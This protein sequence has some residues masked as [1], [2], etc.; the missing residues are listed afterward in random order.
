MLSTT[1]RKPHYQSFLVLT[2]DQL[3]LSLRFYAALVRSDLRLGRSLVS[4]VP[5]PQQYD[6]R[7]RSLG[8][9][10]FSSSILGKG[11]PSSSRFEDSLQMRMLSLTVCEYPG[12]EEKTGACSVGIH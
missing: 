7:W 10:R 1:D 8:H 9:D 2:L 12:S 3:K 5:S 6:S 11:S 4:R